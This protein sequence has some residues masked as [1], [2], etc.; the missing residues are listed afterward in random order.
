MRTLIW[1]YL[2]VASIEYNE[3]DYFDMVCACAM[4]MNEVA[5]QKGMI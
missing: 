4:Q 2:E 1:M 3:G 5:G